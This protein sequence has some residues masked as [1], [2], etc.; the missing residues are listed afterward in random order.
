MKRFWADT[1][2]LN[3]GVPFE[4]RMPLPSI[5]PP[6]HLHTTEGEGGMTA[7]YLAHTTLPP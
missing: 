6:Y 7:I 3:T 2:Q 1:P 5:P 4:P